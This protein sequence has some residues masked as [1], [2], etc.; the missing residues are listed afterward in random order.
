M[1]FFHS[2]GYREQIFLKE[3]IFS[4]YSCS[5]TFLVFCLLQLWVWHIWGRKKAQR[6]HRCCLSSKIFGHSTLS[7]PLES[8][9]ATQVALV[10]KNPP[11]NEGDMRDLGSIPGSGR[12]PGEGDSC[13]ENPVDRGAWW[14]TIHDVTKSWT[15][16]RM[17]THACLFCRWFPGLLFIVSLKVNEKFCRGIGKTMSAPLFFSPRSNSLFCLLI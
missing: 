4:F 14:A 1:P 13:L 16:L 8:S 17:H 5:L 11:A 3:H 7:I 10:V 6:N 9:W 12:S 15:W 2:F